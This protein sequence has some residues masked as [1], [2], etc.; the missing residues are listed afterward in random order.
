VSLTLIWLPWRER[1]NWSGSTKHQ[2]HLRNESAPWAPA[3]L[4]KKT[5]LATDEHGLRIQKMVLILNFFDPW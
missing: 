3:A 4:H 1:A 2:P 5:N